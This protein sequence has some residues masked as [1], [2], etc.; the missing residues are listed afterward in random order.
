MD[1][2]TQ[3]MSHQDSR[4]KIFGN[5]FKISDIGRHQCNISHRKLSDKTVDIWTKDRLKTNKSPIFQR[6]TNGVKNL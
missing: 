2:P 6:A 5:F 1:D 4:L 3:P